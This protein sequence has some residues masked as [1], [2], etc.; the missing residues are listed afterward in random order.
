MGGYFSGIQNSYNETQR[1][2]EGLSAAE[3][4][5]IS[6]HPMAA[7]DFNDDA[8]KA[9]AEAA[10]RFPSA[11]LHN[12]Q[13]DAFRHCYWNALMTRDQN[14]DLARQFGNAHE[15]ERP[16]AGDISTLGS[17]IESM[18]DL[19]NNGKGQEIGKANP[20]ATDAV[21]AS[22]CVAALNADQL[23]VIDKGQLVKSKSL[24]PYTPSGPRPR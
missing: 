9:L 15:M 6:N 5:F 22:L 2:A 17:V 24:L 1:R 11:S 14:A 10:N 12:G 4:V 13:G 16:K 23:L 19:H 21:L 18:M 8:K 3:H 7:K 20:K